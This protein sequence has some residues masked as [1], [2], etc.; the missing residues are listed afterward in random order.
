MAGAGDA[1]VLLPGSAV[2]AA[3]SYFYGVART[4]GS[5]AGGQA[6]GLLFRGPGGRFWIRARASARSEKIAAL[7][8]GWHRAAFCGEGI[9]AVGYS[10]LL[11]AR[12]HDRVLGLP[13][14]WARPSDL[15]AASP[16]GGSRLHALS[17]MSSAALLAATPALARL[18][19]WRQL[20]RRIGEAPSLAGHSHPGIPHVPS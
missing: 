8:P 9:A 11:S 4:N 6:P 1:L 17:I 15:R 14:D 2:L 20:L 18:A 7:A 12:K 5:P 19:G 16:S 10:K 3:I 13:V